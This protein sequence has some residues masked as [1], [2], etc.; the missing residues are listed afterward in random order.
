MRDINEDTRNT[1][2]MRNDLRCC[3]PG[4]LLLEIVATIDAWL[5]TTSPET[6]E[7]CRRFLG[8]VAAAMHDEV[9]SL[10]KRINR[11]RIGSSHFGTDNVPW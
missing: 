9:S 11:L 7:V 4:A 2:S 6:Q 8:D 10:Q 1:R 5:E 3:L